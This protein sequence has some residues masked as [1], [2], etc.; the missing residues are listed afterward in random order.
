MINLAGQQSN[1]EITKEL[2]L[3]GI[4]VVAHE[5]MLKTEPITNLTGRLGEF[6]FKRAWYYWVVYGLVPLEIAQ[7]MYQDPVGK[8]DVR[9]SG[10][11]GCPPPEEWAQPSDEVQEKIKESLGYRKDMDMHETFDFWKINED[12]FKEEI[13]KYDQYINCY[14]IDSQ[15]GLNLFVQILKENNVIIES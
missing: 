1:C 8:K 11:C 9:V 2:N 3:A 14:H 15:E 12:K 4:T 10:H 7:K 6:T 13:K 5:E